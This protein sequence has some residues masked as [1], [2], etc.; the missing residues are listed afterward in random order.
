VNDTQ[1]GFNRQTQIQKF[2]EVMG[3][4]KRNAS[5]DQSSFEILLHALLA[6]EAGGVRHDVLAVAENPAGDLEIVFRL[7]HPFTRVRLQPLFATKECACNKVRT[8]DFWRRKWH[9]SCRVN[10]TSTHQCLKT[11]YNRNGSS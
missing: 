6:K 8:L 4:G 3:S 5:L 2:E 10:S 9:L 7:L 1:S 11:S